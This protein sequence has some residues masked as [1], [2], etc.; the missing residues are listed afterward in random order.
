VVV[1]RAA[2]DPTPISDAD[3]HRIVQAIRAA[4]QRASGELVAMID[5]GPSRP[6]S[7]L[8]WAALAALL[9]PAPWL[10]LWPEI[11]AGQLYLA[12]L[13]L[14]LGLGAL[15]A[16]TGWQHRLLPPPL[17]RWWLRR[18]ARQLF[19]ERGLDQTAGRTGV[20]LFLS[21]PDHHV[22]IVADAGIDR[23]VPPRTWDQAVAA[24]IAEVQADRLVEGCLAAI[25]QI[26]DQLA[27]HFPRDP[28]DAN[29]LPDRLIEI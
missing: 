27:R 7:A 15:L 21:L 8:L 20:L 14:A 6:G 9:L 4:E 19:V 26:G 12:Q 10:T 17:R 22:E 5:H 13:A 1:P 11:S 24:C 16:L 25:Q 3:C 28:G 23:V 29:E 18:R 2:G